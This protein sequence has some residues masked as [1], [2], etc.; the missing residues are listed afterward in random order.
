MFCPKCGKE[1]SN[2]VKFC[3]FCGAPMTMPEQPQG[4]PIPEMPE[5]VQSQPTPQAEPMSET[6]VQPVPE[7]PVQ[8]VSET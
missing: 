5:Q 4:Q 2:D 7:I 8:P 3:C 1:N 6:P